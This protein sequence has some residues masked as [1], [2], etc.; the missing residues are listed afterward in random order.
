MQLYKIKFRMVD[1][2][3]G[4]NDP[5]ELHFSIENEDDDIISRLKKDFTFE[6]GNSW[7]VSANRP[8]IMISSYGLKWYIR[9][10]LGHVEGNRKYYNR[11]TNAV[12][13]KYDFN[14]EIY[15]KYLEIRNKFYIGQFDPV[16]GIMRI[17]VKN[18]EDNKPDIVE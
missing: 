5:C 6:A 13:Y 17:E 3:N 7:I 9:G 2:K 15:K 1:I 12:F 18:Q 11:T 4:S 8:A 14:N 16:T 10:S